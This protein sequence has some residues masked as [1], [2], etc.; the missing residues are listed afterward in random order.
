MDTLIATAFA[1]LFAG[2]RVIEMRSSRKM[3]EGHI[4]HMRKLQGEHRDAM[5][6][7]SLQH[8]ADIERER[9]ESWREGVRMGAEATKRKRDKAGRF[10]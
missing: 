7:L 8:E 1:A 3:R 5:A 10:A 2:C 6:T 9:S 4:D